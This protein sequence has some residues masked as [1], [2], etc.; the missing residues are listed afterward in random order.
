MLS[1]EMT[2][3]TQ[4]QLVAAR[5]TLSA[6]SARVVELE[7][8]LSLQGQQ[9]GQSGLAG[10][11][12]PMSEQM[13]LLNKLG[14]LPTG[15]KLGMSTAKAPSSSSSSS[16]GQPIGI[17][18]VKNQAGAAPPAPTPQ[19]TAH[20]DAAKVLEVLSTLT[21]QSRG[22]SEQ[23][24]SANDHLARALANVGASGSLARIRQDANAATQKRQR[25]S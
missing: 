18:L 2:A 20:E 21:P 1:P 19:Q 16:V 25:T 12:D 10:P 14:L 22:G 4:A 9:T 3:H 11:A 13:A 23:P 24:M 6:I 15:Q 7:C 17:P 8:L 5:A